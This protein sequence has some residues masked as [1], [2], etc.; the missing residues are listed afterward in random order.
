MRAFR[1]GMHE[2][3]DEHGVYWRVYK[4]SATDTRGSYVGR[5]YDKETM[6]LLTQAPAMRRLMDDQKKF[7]VH[8]R[9]ALR[10]RS[11]LPRTL[12]DFTH[13]FVDIFRKL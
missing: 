11:Y 13:A 2:D 12:R 7:G 3:R 8:P 6:E 10:K 4:F 9:M 5:I 1:Y